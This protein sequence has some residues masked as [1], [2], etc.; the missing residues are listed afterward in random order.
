MT[1]RPHTVSIA[2]DDRARIPFALIAVLLLVSSIMIVGVLESRDTPTVDTDNALAMDRAE[3]V[4]VGELRQAVLRA[5]DDAASAPV[6][7]TEGADAAFSNVVDEDEAVFDQ[8]FKLLIYREVSESFA[9]AEQQV[10]QDTTARASVERIDWDDSDD[11]EAAIDRVSIDRRE[12]G[13][14]TVDVDG[15]ELTVTESDGETV[16]EQR[17]LSV[18]VGTPLYQLKDRTEEFQS[19]L[20]KGF[21]ETDGYDGF[22]RYFAARMYPYTWGK[23]YYDRLSS[24]DR[25]F[26]NLTPNEHTEVMVN[27]AVFGLQE[28]TFGT[29]DPYKDRAMLLPTLCMGSDLA[30]SAGDVETED[31]LPGGENNSL[32][33]ESNLC[34]ADLIDAEGE[35]PDAPTVQDIVLTMLEDNVETD[36]EIQAH[37]FA[38]VSYMQMAAGM[39]MNQVE[40]EFNE[41]LIKTGRFN[42]KYLSNYF[43][44]SVENQGTAGDIG[45]L[46]DNGN[47]VVDKINSLYTE[48]APNEDKISNIISEI[49]NIEV[50]TKEKSLSKQDSLPEPSPP[51][52]WAQN[53]ENWTG[54]VDKTYHTDGSS[55]D[56]DV[57]IHITSNHN[58][59]QFDDRNLAEIEIIYEASIG[60]RTKWEH[61]NENRSSHTN[62]NW[63]N[64]TYS[65]SYEIT[66]DF[67]S[68]T[69][70]AERDNRG[71]QTL[72]EQDSWNE[73]YS[74]VGNFEGVEAK[75]VK[76]TFGLSSMTIQ[77][78]E[79]EIESRIESSS[80]EIITKQ[81]FKRSI[82]YSANPDV[83]M[84]PRNKDEI[85]EWVLGELNQTHYEVVTQV[86]PHQ[87]NLWDMVEKPSPLSE[88]RKNVSDLERELVYQNSTGPY[89]NTA[90]I[91]RTEVRKQYFEGTYDNIDQISDWH[92]ET[93]GKSSAIVNNLLGGLLDSSNDLLGEPMDFID[94]MTDPKTRPEDAK[95]SLNESPLMADLNYQVEAAPT[96]L[97]LDTVNRTEVPAV[98]PED[99]DVLEVNK[100]STKHA[101]MGAGYFD[102]IGHPGF[103]LM[104]WPSL[105]YLQ[106]DSYYLEV[107][108]EYAR[109]KVRTNSG[110]PTSSGE[111]TYTSQ[112]TKITMDTPSWAEQE[113]LA[114]GSV[115]PISF[116]SSLVVPI[117]VPSPQ[118]LAKGTPGVGDTWKY[119]DTD[120]PREDCSPTWENIGAS[121]QK[122]ENTPCISD[123]KAGTLPV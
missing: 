23:A 54:P 26:H 14:L 11:L 41:S 121:F 98:R 37:P 82:P 84:N 36:V 87:T 39:D 110:N 4:A 79:S 122:K 70:S 3:S 35:L 57:T 89:N 6:T 55:E 65:A 67:V 76:E 94:K 114:V 60:V 9:T 80:N 83:E 7:S 117:V 105:F 73:Q 61:D 81:D 58:N 72:V 53:P 97:S 100:T 88:M 115:E 28:K 63:K 27:D 46:S 42:D 32:A 52:E 50:K 13:V 109:F 33:N 2:D 17:S 99:S 106:L 59:T 91:L 92:D 75:S 102:G 21:F 19:Q 34:N 93:L 108:G 1:D 47:G 77:S 74:I 101:P 69:I 5:A 66:G 64:V 29:T 44:D 103:P 85:Y 25:A 90:D 16:T 45:G 22:G 120:S 86:E 18:T 118:L 43:S 48:N 31:F 12:P 56:A 62:W 104:P 68:D 20:N 49:Y 112:E 71:I 30:S 78:Q 24:G 38:D 51:D 96:Y 40:S 113:E 123:E 111:M 119:R 8:Y 116:N 15:I 10:D 95:E 107:Q